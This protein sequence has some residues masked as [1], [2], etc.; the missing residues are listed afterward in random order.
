LNPKHKKTVLFAD[1]DGTILDDQYSY[2]ETQP[3]INHLLTDGVAVVFVSSKTRSEIQHY[4]HQLGVSDPFIVENGSA[5][6]IPKGYFHKASKA[7]KET[8]DYHIIELGTPYQ[9]IRQKL[10]A[11]Q[12]QTSTQLKGYGDMSVEEITQDSGL[13][14]TLA[15]LAKNREYDEP[16]KILQGNVEDVLAAI[17]AV[18]LCYS[19]GGRYYH[20]LGDS[21]KGKAVA[22]LTDLYRREF[23]EVLTLGI[24]D[25][26]ND[27]PLL[28]AVEVPFWLGVDAKKPRVLIWKELVETALK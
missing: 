23:G 15:A 28:S 18:G 17:G 11:V 3:L 27:L 2:K 21:D 24:G 13:S 22:I 7:T 20:A 8:P 12:T 9:T 10:A 16:F 25:S 19:R 4:Q 1:L 14:P 5:I 26:A 6:Y